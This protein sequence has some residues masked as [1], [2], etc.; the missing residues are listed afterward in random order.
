M[1]LRHASVAAATE[2][3]RHDEDGDGA[4]NGPQDR[5]SRQPDKRWQSKRAHGDERR[6]GPGQ[7]RREDPARSNAIA[8]DHL[9]R[10]ASE[11]DDP[12]EG[13]RAHQQTQE[14]PEQQYSGEHRQ[15]D[16]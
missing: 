14:D 1:P 8:G 3:A 15:R 5:D 12:D 9:P 2:N 7:A 6:D 16:G 10:Q 4:E 11:E 13:Q